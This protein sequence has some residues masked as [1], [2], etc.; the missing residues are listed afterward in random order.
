MKTLIVIF[1]GAFLVACIIGWLLERRD[2]K[3]RDDI[4]Y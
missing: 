3:R 4:A 1:G 2:R